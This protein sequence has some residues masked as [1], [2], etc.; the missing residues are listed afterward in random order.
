MNRRYYRN[1]GDCDAARMPGFRVVRLRRVP[2]MTVVGNIER[3]ALYFRGA[4]EKGIRA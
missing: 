2:G 3:G 1:V 4:A